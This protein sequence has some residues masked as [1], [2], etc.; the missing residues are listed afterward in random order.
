MAEALR[1]P[2]DLKIIGKAIANGGPLSILL[3]RSRLEEAAVKSRVGGTYSKELF[4]VACALATDEVMTAYDGY[5]RVSAN[6]KWVA[7]KF[8]DAFARKGFLGLVKI[9]PVLSNTMMDIV[10]SDEVLSN[11]DAR[12]ALI[13]TLRYNG[14][15]IL[16]AHPSF[17]SVVHDDEQ[18]E[19]ISG[20]LAAAL[21]QWR[22]YVT[23]IT[24]PAAEK[25]TPRS[26]WG[27]DGGGA[28]RFRGRHPRATRPVLM[29]SMASSI[30][31]TRSLAIS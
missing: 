23:Y 31:A 24:L 26:A 7:D 5:N 3:A 8:N 17:V 30:E 11:Y 9:E 13:D 27:S 25:R 4:G 19:N 1:I 28:V 10:W 2:W 16:D 15:L 14:I 21:D 18:L 22:P 6:I 20:V 12:R 29:T